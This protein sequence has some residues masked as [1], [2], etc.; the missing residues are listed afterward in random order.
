MPYEDD[1]GFDVRGLALAVA[2]SV[3]LWIAI[4]WGVAQ[5]FG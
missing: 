4:L 1:D 2:I 3:L 5:L